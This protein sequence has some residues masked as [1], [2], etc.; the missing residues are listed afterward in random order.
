[1]DINLCISFLDRTRAFMVAHDNEKVIH[2]HHLY[3]LDVQSP[4]MR[5]LQEFHCQIKQG[6][7]TYP[8]MAPV[9]KMIRATA[10]DLQSATFAILF[11]AIREQLSLVDSA[12]MIEIIWASV[13]AGADTMEPDMPDFSF[14]PQEYITQIGQVSLSRSFVS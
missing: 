6:N 5:D 9:L 14:S 10:E 3:L 1:M 12:T 8:I 2:Q 4:K 13:S 11:H 7:V